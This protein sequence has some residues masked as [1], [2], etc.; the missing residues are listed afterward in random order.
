MTIKGPPRGI[1]R[2]EYEYQIPVDHAEEM[3]ETLCG[4]LVEKH[5]VRFYERPTAEE[6]ARLF[7]EFGCLSLE[8]DPDAA[9]ELRLATGVP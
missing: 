1:A 5:K 6:A 2:A 3:L 9:K 4:P 7:L 8:L